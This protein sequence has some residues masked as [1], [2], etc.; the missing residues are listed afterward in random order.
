M[1]A[2]VAEA[3]AR[4]L[5]MLAIALLEGAFVLSRAMRTT[6]PVELAGTEFADWLGTTL[7]AAQ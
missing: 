2:G 5:A 6:E 4:E 3:R 7:P 1:E